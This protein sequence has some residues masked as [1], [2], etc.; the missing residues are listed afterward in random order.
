MVTTLDSDEEYLI[1]MKTLK[2]LLPTNSEMNQMS[3][4]ETLTLNNAIAYINYLNLI[5][6]K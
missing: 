4:D 2:E 1:L 3:N 6:S 5:L